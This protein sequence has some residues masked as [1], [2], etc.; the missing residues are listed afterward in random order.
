[1]QSFQQIN[2]SFTSSECA[3]LREAIKGEC[4]S[5]ISYIQMSDDLNGTVDRLIADAH[6]RAVARDAVQ[7]SARAISAMHSARRSTL[8]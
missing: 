8:N 4:Q 7:V 6:T 1:M 5:E 2:Q 3:S